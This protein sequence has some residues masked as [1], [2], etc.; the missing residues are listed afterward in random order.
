LTVRKV[1]KGSSTNWHANPTKMPF[2]GGCGVG[3]GLQLV[4]ER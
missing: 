1:M 3:S 2:L 4:R